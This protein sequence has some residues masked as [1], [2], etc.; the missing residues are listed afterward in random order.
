MC[1][2]C[3]SPTP[4]C[5]SLYFMNQQYKWSTLYPISQTIPPFTVKLV[6]NEHTHATRVVRPLT[7]VI[8]DM[9]TTQGEPPV[10][11]SY[12]IIWCVQSSNSKTSWSS[13]RLDPGRL[14][15]Q[16]TAELADGAVPYSSSNAF[17][18]VYFPVLSNIQLFVQ[19]RLKNHIDAGSLMPN[20]PITRQPPG[21]IAQV[22]EEVCLK[23][24]SSETLSYLIF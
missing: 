23:F 3:S 22:Q 19:L 14:L 10:L 16:S 24:K 11:C 8:S 5:K 20:C 21:I 6:F 12:W 7:G 13:W 18:L 17:F 9:D 4:H 2:K 1:L 15:S